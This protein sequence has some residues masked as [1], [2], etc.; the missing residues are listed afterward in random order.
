ML[1]LL[2]ELRKTLQRLREAEALA[3]RLGDDPRRG[4]VA[5][6][7]TNSHSQLGEPDEALASGTRALEI[8]GRL[9]DVKLRILTTGYLAQAYYYRGEYERVVK[10]ATD[11]LAV[12]PTD[13]IYELVGNAA[14]AAVYDRHWLVMSLAELGRF[15]EAAELLA[16]TGPPLR[17]ETFIGKLP[18]T[19]MGRWSVMPTPVTPP[20]PGF[21]FAAR[22]PRSPCQVARVSHVHTADWF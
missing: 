1:I 6:F 12:L 5:A 3:E 15:T 19:P 22:F 21:C 18:L 16:E 8:A 14:T 2:G 17:C 9:G 11:N 20:R 4:R 10:L 13:W 7:V